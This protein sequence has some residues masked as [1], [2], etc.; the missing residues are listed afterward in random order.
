[1]RFL[2]SVAAALASTAS[3]AVSAATNSSTPVSWDALAISAPENGR[4]LYRTNSGEP[5]FWQGDTAWELFHRLNRSDID[6]Y[7]KER[8]SKG[9]N[10]VQAVV[11][12]ELNGTTFPN[13]NGDLPLIDRDPMRPNDAY[14]EHVDWAVNRAAEYGILIAMVPTWG[15][16][17]NCGW[18]NES[19]VI[20]NETNANWY[21]SYI[22]KRYPGLP[23][24]IGADSNGFW[25]CNISSAQAAWE[26]DTSLDPSSLVGPVQD[27][28]SV[29][30]SM[31]DGLREAEA[32]KGFT[33][34]ITWHPTNQNRKGTVKPY[35]HNVSDRIPDGEAL[36]HELTDLQQYM[37]GTFGHLS[38]DA[39]QSGHGLADHTTLGQEFYMLEQWDSTKNYNNIS[40][41]RAAFPGPVIDLENHYEGAHYS[42]NASKPYWSTSDVRHGLW[43]AFLSGSAGFTYGQQG[44]WQMYAPESQLA[45][46]ELYMAPRLEQPAGES[47][48]EALDY[49]GSTQAG[50]LRQLFSGV[51]KATFNSMQPDRTFIKTPEDSTEDVLDFEANRY[52]AG[53]VGSSHYWV[54]SGFGDTFAVDLGAL[55]LFWGKKNGTASSQWY[56]PRTG[57]FQDATES[58]L[59][60][61]QQT[62]EP[63]TGGTVDEDWALVLEAL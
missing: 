2:L 58:F 14:F 26:A 53:L 46:P 63:P 22:G 47:W 50:Y 20:F 16:Y 54:Y 10:I 43:N 61:G 48:R 60:Q 45:Y 55:G 18:Y 5:F 12:S 34:F 23:K 36:L 4:Y 13:F 52:V 51:D 8:A 11:I 62:F 56:D 38:M 28:R 37:N 15:M 57:E 1:M 29:W 35:G 39:V 7:L 59:L 27:T 31:A 42:F 3:V 33:S 40:E 9:F 41:M 32:E 6:F 30:S 49:P 44:V 17:V 24:I 19:V 21:G 25:S